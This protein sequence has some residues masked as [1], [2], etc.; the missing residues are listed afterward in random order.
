MRG[1]DKVFL[2][3]QHQY[4]LYVL[5]NNHHDGIYLSDSLNHVLI[6]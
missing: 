3:F 5:T 6:S 4:P 1:M 2:Q